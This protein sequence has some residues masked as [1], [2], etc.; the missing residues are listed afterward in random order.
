[1]DKYAEGIKR[2]SSTFGAVPDF[3]AN[4]VA[5]INKVSLSRSHRVKQA[6]SLVPFLL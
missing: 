3:D 2:V 1:M 6:C 5:E 4:S